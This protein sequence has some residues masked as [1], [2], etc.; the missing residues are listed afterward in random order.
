M[1]FVAALHKGVETK[2]P[3]VTFSPRIG[4]GARW[5]NPA[6]R[7][8]EEDLF[9]HEIRQERAD[10]EN[11]E[12]HRLLYVAM[13]RAEQHLALTF[14]ATARKTENW[15][16][17]VSESLQLP[18]T[19]T[20]DRVIDR[21][22][23]D[24]KPWKLRLLVTDRAPELLLRVPAARTAGAASPA[25]T[26]LDAPAVTEQQDA[27]ATVTA[28]VEYAR[29]P[30][31]YYLGH[32]LG[33]DGRSRGVAEPGEG[34]PASDLGT[35]V[36]K[37]LAGEAVADADDEALRLADNFRNSA[38][39]RRAAKAT[40]AEREFDFL[41]AV[42]DLVIRGQVDLWF[43][44]GGELVIVDYKTDAVNLAEAH[45]RAQD[46]A[47]Q[48]RLYAMAVEQLTGRAADRA[49]LCFLRPNATVE[50]DLAPS[51]IESPS[52]VVRE[53]QE[54]QDSLRFPLNEE[55]HCHGCP[56]FHDLCPATGG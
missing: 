12:S 34:L 43:E 29:C 27:N 18:L 41:M 8:D 40:R 5:R 51:L 1:V 13:T 56:F 52:E 45:R 14:S 9:Q 42:D 47:L 39:G 36:H 24:G 2:L 7:E 10:R 17:L 55:E 48:L 37:L 44:E 30:R 16:K 21:A 26:W 33:F 38:L 23:P 31:R 32:Y 25:T 50:I 3:V 15:A 46:Y 22:A 28:L 54:A 53:F 19:E 4:L 20:G 49:Y 35:Q 6:R 11:Q